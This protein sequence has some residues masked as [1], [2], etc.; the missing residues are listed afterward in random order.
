M[1][2]PQKSINTSRCCFLCLCYL[3]LFTDPWGSAGT[4]CP[5]TA[6]PV[7]VK[8]LSAPLS[9]PWL[10]ALLLSVSLSVKNNG[11]VVGDTSDSHIT[12][13]TGSSRTIKPKLQPHQCVAQL[14]PYKHTPHFSPDTDTE[15]LP[16][17]PMTPLYMQLDHILLAPQQL[18]ALWDQFHCVTTLQLQKQISPSSMMKTW[19]DSKTKW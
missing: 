19:R 16:L 1:N 11:C 9:S 3:A 7:W 13:I 18:I 12:K 10:L 6:H 17:W 15:W 4:A 8:K 5:R 14:K 2:K